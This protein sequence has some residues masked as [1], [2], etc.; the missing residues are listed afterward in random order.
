[1]QILVVF[2]V[3]RLFNSEY[4]LDSYHKNSNVEDLNIEVIS[5][6]LHSQE[7]LFSYNS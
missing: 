1:M 6:L 5:C 7:G 2:I 4:K 3:E